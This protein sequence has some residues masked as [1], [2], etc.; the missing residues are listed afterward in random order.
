MS[1]SCSLNISSNFGKSSSLIPC[2]IF[3]APARCLLMDKHLSC[4]GLACSESSDVHLQDVRVTPTPLSQ[5]K[6]SVP[7]SRPSPHPGWLVDHHD[8]TSPMSSVRLFELVYRSASSEPLGKISSSA[9]R[10]LHSV[11]RR[12]PHSRSRSLAY[13]IPLPTEVSVHMV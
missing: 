5:S 1:G 8:T 13:I 2:H 9:W 7:L 12:R 11:L 4:A 10:D 6:K 3:G